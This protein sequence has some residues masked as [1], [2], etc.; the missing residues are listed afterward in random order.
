M[1]LKL[2]NCGESG[3]GKTGALASLCAAG[4]NVRVLD[5]DNGVETLINILNDPSSKYPKDAIS[6]LRWLTLTEPMRVIGGNIVPRQAT[7]YQKAVE[8]LENWKGDFR[9]DPASGE[10]VPCED[11]LGTVYNWTERDVLVLDTLT[12]LGSGAVNFALQMQ[13]KLGTNR[14]SIEA[15]RDAGSAQGMIEK[16]LQFMGDDH[17]KC[18]V[19]INTHLNWAKEDGKT[20]ELGY[21]GMLYGFPSAFGKALN[22]KVGRGFN[23]M[24][25]TRK[26][27][28]EFR[29]YTKGVANVGVKSSA[30]LRVK[31]SYPVQ[32]GLADYIA[33]VN[34]KTPAA[35]AAKPT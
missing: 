22:L 19:I 18:N 15:M 32:T 26:V 35:P 5:L 27:G 31:E 29:I 16:F 11:K 34:R 10:N 1:P 25:L 6:R 9:F 14:T 24:L 23:H 33:D 28:V 7:V 20:P 13:G 2:I 12:S 30:P 3:S 17:L 21:E 4:Y 8:M